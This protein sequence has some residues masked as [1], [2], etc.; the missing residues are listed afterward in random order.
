MELK[1]ACYNG[2]TNRQQRVVVRGTYSSWSPVRSGVPQGTILG[3][4]LFLI[5]V[6]DI[7]SNIPSSHKMYADDT[8]VYRELSNLET[9]TRALQSDIDRLNGW[10]TLWPLRFNPVKCETMRI[11]HNRDKSL[12]S[13]TTGPELKSVKNAKDLGVLISSDLS[14]S[15]HVDAVVNKANKVLGVVHRTLGPSNQEAFSILYKT[16]VRPILECA[17]LLWCPYLG[18]DILALERVQRRASRLA[19]GQKRAG[20]KWTTKIGLKC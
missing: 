10:A 18:K 4:I 16:L 19:L 17:V 3:P 7:S 12:P 11:A 8:K 20:E 14:W 5:Y 13:Y 1:V 6:N 9:D 2:L 15:A